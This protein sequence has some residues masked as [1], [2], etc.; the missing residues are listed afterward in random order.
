MKKITL[1]FDKY[2]F[3]MATNAYNEKMEI[4]DKVENITKN[5]LDVSIVVDKSTDLKQTIFKAIEDKHKPQNFLNLS[6]EKLVELMEIN[7]NPILEAAKFL[8]SF[9]N[10]DKGTPPA[11]DAFTLSVE[12]EQ[13]LA[14]YN[15]ALKAIDTIKQ[16]K[17][18]TN[19]NRDYSAYMRAFAGILKFN[20]EKMEIE[21][22]PTFVKNN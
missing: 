8:D 17:A 20:I 19:D 22:S 2:A 3:E 7:I 9:D 12:N 16:A 15:F 4:I 5:L 13:E 21:P 11:V 14:R 10:I 18:L 6:G 1:H